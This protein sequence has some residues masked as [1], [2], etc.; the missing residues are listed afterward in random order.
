M[1]WDDLTQQAADRH[2]NVLGGFHPD[3]TDDVPAGAQTLV[4]LGPKEPEF[5]THIQ[6][7]S[8]WDGAPDPIDRWSSRV[9]GDWAAQ[10][11]AHA[12]FPFGGPPY[13]PFFSWALKTGRIHASPI[14]FLVHD[15]AGLFV[16]FRGALA[17]TE[18]LDISPPPPSPCSTCAIQPCTTACPVDAFDG[19]SYNTTACKAHLE[20]PQDQDC[21]QRGCA[22][23]RACPVSKSW[24]R[25]EKQSAYHMGIFKG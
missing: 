12:L 1:N 3:D 22:A 6:T 5:W 19:A 23:R 11:N 2:L 17:L 24:G 4:L 21:M 10:L 13:K 9:I 16:S 15:Q 20:A 8:E 25:P 7:Q 18:T 14:M